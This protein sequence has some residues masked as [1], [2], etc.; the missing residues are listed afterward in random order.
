MENESNM[1]R[2]QWEAKAIAK[3]AGFRSVADML[4]RRKADRR[5]ESRLAWEAAE[6]RG[7]AGER[8]ALA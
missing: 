4:E 8:E 1:T 7:T 6:R 5:K 3:R 2:A